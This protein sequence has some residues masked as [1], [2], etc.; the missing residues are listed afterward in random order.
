M[1]FASSLLLSNV[2]DW[3]TC[4]PPKKT[5]KQVATLLI[6]REVRD[7]FIDLKLADAGRAWK[8][9]RGAAAAITEE[10]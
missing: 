3:E 9:V 4:K 7:N 2:Y 5:N 1:K 10:Q 8:R 6:A